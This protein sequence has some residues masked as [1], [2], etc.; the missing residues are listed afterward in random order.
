VISIDLARPFG[1]L[2]MLT[3]ASRLFMNTRMI[4]PKPSVTIAR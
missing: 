1:P 2:V 4:S 3:G